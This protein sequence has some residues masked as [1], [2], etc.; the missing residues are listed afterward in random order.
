MPKINFAAACKASTYAPPPDTEVP[1]EKEKE[2]VAVA[3]L[4]ITSKA[5]AREAKKREAEGDSD[6][7]VGAAPMEGIVKGDENAEAAEGKKKK[8]KT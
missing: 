2:K 8:Q 6:E 4:S 5:K 1:K 7:A 3:V